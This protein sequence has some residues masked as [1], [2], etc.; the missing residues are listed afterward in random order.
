[1]VHATNGG[2]PLDQTEMSERRKQRMKESGW[3]EPVPP[4]IVEMMAEEAYSEATVP[5]RIGTPI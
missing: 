3:L 2:Q 1:M 5:G 4:Y